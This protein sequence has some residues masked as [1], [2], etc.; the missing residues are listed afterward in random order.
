MLK[1]IKTLLLIL[2]L[3]L[4]AVLGAWILVDNGLLVSVSVFGFVF[5]DV[6]LGVVLCI[7]LAGGLLLGFVT[8]FSLLQGR[9]YLQA[10]KYRSLSKE[11]ASPKSGSSVGP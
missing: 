7:A 4:V 8:A 2:W 11:V 1:R 6:S 3:L 10:R 9:L 5:P